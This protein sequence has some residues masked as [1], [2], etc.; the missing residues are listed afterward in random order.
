MWLH[1]IL[2]QPATVSETIVIDDD[3][4]DSL[5]FTCI[6]FMGKLKMNL[7]IGDKNAGK[8]CLD[9]FKEKEQKGKFD[10]NAAY[11]W[12][13]V[14][15]RLLVLR[16]SIMTQFVT[17]EWILGVINWYKDHRQPVQWD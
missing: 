16:I 14:F 4:R 17:A 2:Q 5:T 13:D 1:S 11:L 6:D 10:R 7:N 15:L 12:H 8:I 9:N 3:N